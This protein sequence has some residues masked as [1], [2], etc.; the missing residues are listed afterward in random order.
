M[1]AT[2]F[3]RMR[4]L[5][6]D[7]CGCCGR[8]T[9]GSVWCTDCRGHIKPPALGQTQWERTW[10]AQHEKECPFMFEPIKPEYTR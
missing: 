3:D 10:F 1:S 8:E 9:P 4:R 7:Y 6:K 2:H 5:D